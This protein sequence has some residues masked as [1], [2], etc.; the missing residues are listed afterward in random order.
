MASGDEVTRLLRDLGDE[1]G[2]AERLLT[3]VY[4]E[5]RAIAARRMAGERAGH[6]LQATVLVH[7]AWMR[8]A[9]SRDL[10]WPDRRAFFAAAAE[11]M[12]RILVDHARRTNA[13]R[14]GG[15]ARPLPLDGQD[16]GADEEVDVVALGDALDRLEAEDP[17]AA[18]VV[19]LRFFA[20]LSVEET[21]AAL[22]LSERTV[23][24]EWSFARARLHQ[25]LH[26]ES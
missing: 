13:V 10:P 3:L 8:L 5:L 14:R 16:P 7:E 26:G 6:T 15:G 12:R 21:S 20:G 9:G 25:L 1:P 17:R 4:D 11:A 19:R 23:L 24:R 22:E 18:E 2:A